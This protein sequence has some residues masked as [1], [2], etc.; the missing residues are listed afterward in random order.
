MLTSKV[1]SVLEGNNYSV[2]AATVEQISSFKEKKECEKKMVEKLPLNSQK[3]FWSSYCVGSYAAHHL[4]RLYMH[5]L[6]WFLLIFY[7]FDLPIEWSV[8]EVVLVHSSM[9]FLCFKQ[10]NRK[11]KKE[12]NINFAH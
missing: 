8:I 1:G 4:I 7:L 9:K 2:T 11:R 10:E 6:L 5:R 3:P 12:M